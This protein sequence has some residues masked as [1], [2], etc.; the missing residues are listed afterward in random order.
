M[1][2][3][4]VRRLSPDSEAESRDWDAYVD[5]KA[6]VGGYQYMVWLRIIREAFGHPVFALAAFRGESLCGVLPLVL[7][8]GGLFGRF[9]VSMPFVNYGGPLADDAEAARALQAGAGTLLDETGARSLELR[10]AAPSGLDLPGRGHKVSMIL[11]LDADPEVQ[12]RGFK[13]KVRNQVRKAQK[14]GLVA[15]QGGEELLDEFYAVFCV[16]MRALG[17]PV[18]GREFFTAVLRGLEDKARIISVHQRGKCLAAGLT[19][20]SPWGLEMPWASSL[21]RYRNLCANNLLY[22]EAIRTACAQGFA[23]FDFGR[24]SPESGPWRFKIQWGAR[25]LPLVWEYLLAPGNG[26]PDLTVQN[27]RYRLAI[28]VW[29]RLPLGLTKVL[30]PRIVRCI[31]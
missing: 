19:T 17:T 6:P 25:E 23:R 5:G 29:K 12:W 20:A 1:P 4:V 11:D 8:A 21:P 15:V 14:S 13:D 3:V 22:W 26:L 7:V 30:G 9:L 18:Y 31:P 10:L 24:S 2:E 28:E 27:P 16:N